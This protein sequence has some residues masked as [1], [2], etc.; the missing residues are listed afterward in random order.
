[1]R[2][3]LSGGGTAGHVSP[4][5]AVADV[6]RRRDKST[7]FIFVGEASGIEARLAREA[8]LTFKSV[9]GGKLRRLPGKSALYNLIDIGQTIRNIFDLARIALGT[10]QAIGVIV[11][12]RPDVIFNKA[13]T[14]GLPV[15][16]A[17]RIL[18][19][20][21]VIHEPDA[22]AGLGNRVLAGWATTVA[23]GFPA[24][25]Y[26]GW[27]ASKLD[28]TGT[29]VRQSVTVGSRV[30]GLDHF[31]LDR[32]LP[33]VLVIGG[34]QGARAINGLVSEAAPLLKHIQIIHVTGPG[35]Y[36][37]IKKMAGDHY[38][39][40]PY[41]REDFGLAYSCADIVVSRAGANTIAEL[42]LLAKPSVIIPNREM[43]AHQI[44]NA[45]RLAQA[46]AAIVLDESKI[47]PKQFA[48]ILQKLTADKPHQVQLSKNIA[49]FA[50]KDAASKLAD[51]IT[52]AGSRS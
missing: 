45:R 19:V 51:I 44:Y 49:K 22:V 2:I 11:A 47:T 14:T 33:V 41:L 3:L 30:A 13:G 4:V 17:A 15:G 43:A 38:V 28:F 26:R 16:M 34:S 40:A 42:A 8:G 46:D 37:Q 9:L 39:V 10:I 20:P 50:A 35:E 24:D 27:H 21:M 7:Q 6:L 31:N 25:V 52:R 1:M 5:L 48:T 32:D 12:F 36:G 18:R 29:P 23:V